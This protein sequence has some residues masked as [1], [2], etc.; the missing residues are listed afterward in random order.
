MH[1]GVLSAEETA[2]PNCATITA[3]LNLQSVLHGD[4]GMAKFW[5][6]HYQTLPLSCLNCYLYW[7]SVVVNCKLYFVLTCLFAERPYE[8][9][10]KGDNL[11][12]IF[13]KVFTVRTLYTNIFLSPYVKLKLINLQKDLNLNGLVQFCLVS[14]N[15]SNTDIL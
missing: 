9:N 8:N 11:L 3:R 1:G 14:Y 2:E 10:L 5:G 13:R 12:K 6:M 4:N 7:I 15:R